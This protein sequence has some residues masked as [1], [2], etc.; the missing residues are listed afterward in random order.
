MASLISKVS[1]AAKREFHGV[2]AGWQS[3]D[4]CI[5]GSMAGCTWPVA[6]IPV[7]G[8]L[9]CMAN[10]IIRRQQRSCIMMI[11]MIVLGQ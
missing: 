10:I 2:F 3:S 7:H 5:G 8:S 1:E 9:W 6:V 4:S 11:L